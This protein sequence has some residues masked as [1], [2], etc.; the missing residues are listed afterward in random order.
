M[1][2]SF[3]TEEQRNRYGR[4]DGE[5]SPEQLTRNIARLR[6]S[7]R[8]HWRRL[9]PQKTRYEALLLDTN[10]LIVAGLGYASE[11][12]QKGSGINPGRAEMGHDIPEEPNKLPGRE[13]RNT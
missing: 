10:V 4:F 13:W 7:R 6:E 5:L 12:L 8:S 11:V 1:P 3:L 9:W 2:V